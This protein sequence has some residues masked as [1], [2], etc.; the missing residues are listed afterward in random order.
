MA[1]EHH[2][3]SHG[4]KEEKDKIVKNLV[5][6]LGI[7]LFFIFESAMSMIRKRRNKKVCYVLFCVS[8]ASLYSDL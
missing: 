3:H 4:A 2:N 5:A 6:V 8:C 7:Y 1:G